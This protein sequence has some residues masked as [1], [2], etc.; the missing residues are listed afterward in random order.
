MRQCC[1]ASCLDRML[2]L[3]LKQKHSV[4]PFIFNKPPHGLAIASDDNHCKLL[5]FVSFRTP[6][7]G[8]SL[9]RPQSVSS[10]NWLHSR[11]L[12]LD[13]S[14][15]T[16]NY[17]ANCTTHCHTMDPVMLNYVRTSHD[18][19]AQLCLI[20]AQC[21]WYSCVNKWSEHLWGLEIY[22]VSKS[23]CWY[24]LYKHSRNAFCPIKMLDEQTVKVS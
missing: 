17:I 11:L 3:A 9:P 2:Y 21:Q 23:H 14:T 24:T 18:Y 8:F 5:Y 19:P 13:T 4:F 7:W 20:S 1:A 12:W 15:N 22:K 16:V 6:Y 10:C